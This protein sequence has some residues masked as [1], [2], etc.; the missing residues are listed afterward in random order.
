MAIKSKKRNQCRLCSSP[1]LEQ[2]VKLQPIP[3]QELYLDTKEHAQLVKRYPIDVYYCHEC[4][5]VQQL[6]I[7]E[8]EMLWQNYTYES[9]K[10]KGM[11]EHFNKFCRHVVDTTNYPANSL[12]VDIG[13]NDGTLLKYFN[14]NKFRVL[15]VD[16]AENLAN[17]A[18]SDGV[19]TIIDIFNMNTVT[20]ILENHGKAKVIT[21]FNAFAHA[22]DLSEIASGIY[23]LLDQD[24]TFYFEVQYLADLIDK[25]LLGSIFHEHMSHHSIIPIQRFLKG[26]GLTLIDVKHTQVQ[27]GAI[28]GTVKKTCSNPNISASINTFVETEKLKKLDSITAI[29]SLNNKI[30][31]LRKKATEFRL[32]L[33]SKTKVFGFGAA[34]SG[35][36]LIS[37]LG[38]EGIITFIADDHPAKVGKYPAGEGI[39]IVPIE[40]W[41]SN[42]PDFTIILAW[43][44]VA[45]I[46]RNNI[47]YLEKGGKFIVLTPQFEIIDIENYSDYLNQYDNSTG[48][49]NE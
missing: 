36:T 14:D 12:I 48:A 33:N 9:G 15:G 45:I 29:K 20:N 41:R 38:L 35:Q 22:D 32:K 34:R 26:H 2:A 19:P 31:I 4:S 3:P 10:A 30:D 28:I 39:H 43:V 49:F 13:S 5:H 21:A 23:R 1:K 7:L 6:D 27:H 42:I 44:H 46:I 25:V 40:I 8:T 16:P 47:K 37:Q 11:K 24:G 18:I 17:K